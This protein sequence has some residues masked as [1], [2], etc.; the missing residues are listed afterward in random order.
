M[1]DIEEKFTTVVSRLTTI[2][3]SKTRDESTKFGERMATRL[4]R[5]QE[6]ILKRIHLKTA[7]CGPAYVPPQPIG[8]VRAPIRSICDLI[9]YNM[10]DLVSVVDTFNSNCPRN[11]NFDEKTEKSLKLLSEKIRDKFSCD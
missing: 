3:Q 10:N 1:V 5:K 8:A 9:T 4:A 6:T 11:D 2:I 7:R